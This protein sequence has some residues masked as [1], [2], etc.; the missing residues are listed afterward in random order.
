MSLEG[1]HLTRVR[2]HWRVYLLHTSSLD[3]ISLSNRNSAEDLRVPGGVWVLGACASAVRLRACDVAGAVWRAL[4]RAPYA[5]VPHPDPRRN[6]SSSEVL[7]CGF[8]F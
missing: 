6:R 7:R 4:H 8:Y 3:E 5:A 2:C 1:L